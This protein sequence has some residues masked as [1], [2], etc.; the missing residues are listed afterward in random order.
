MSADLTGTTLLLDGR[1]DD[2]ATLGLIH[3]DLCDALEARGYT[4]DDWALR[5]ERMAWC[6]G[7]FGCWVKT[8]GVCVHADAGREVAARATRAGLLVYLTPVTF[9]SYSA[10]LKKA[11]DHMV[12]VLLP[13]LKKSGADTRHPQRYDVVR[14]LLVVGTVPAG[15]ADGAEAATFR[16]LVARN[17]LNTRPRR[18][19]VGVLET[20]MG[21][22]DVRPALAALFDELGA[23]PLP[24][25]AREAKEAVA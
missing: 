9:G 6:A 21:E 7:C 8:P 23:R 15:Q 12:P 19:T 3:D 13:Y 5:H 10:E 17:V 20:G 4:V 25:P 1:E 11:L 24:A 18:W 14:D 2:D 22:A 16:R